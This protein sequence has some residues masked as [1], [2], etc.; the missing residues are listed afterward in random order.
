MSKQTSSI[1]GFLKGHFRDGPFIGLD[2]QTSSSSGTT[3]ED[4]AFFYQP[5][6]TITFSIGTL[7]LGHTAGAESLT[8]ANLHCRENESGTLD[9]TRSETIN[10]ARF[11]LSLGLEPDLRSGVL[12][13]SAIRQAVDVQ[14]AGIDFAFDVDVF[15]RA[16]PVRAV[17]DQLG[18]R[19]R[20][21]AEAR[22]HVRR[23]LLG[24]RAFRDVRIRVRNGSTLDADVFVPFKQG[25]YPVLL[26]LSVYGRAF[27]IG[28]NHTQEDREASDERETTWWEDPKSRE[29]INSYFRYSESA[30]SANASDWVP[31]GYVVVRVDARGIG[32]NSGTL[33]PFSLQEA[34]DFYDAIQWAAEQPWSDGNV[35][36]YGASYNGTIQWNVAALQPPA[37]KAIAP[38][39]PDADG[40]RDLAYPGG[41]FLDKYRRYWYDEIVGPAKNPKVPRVNFVGWLASHPWDDEYYHGQGQGMLSADFSKVHIPVLTSV[42]Q[43]L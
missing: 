33:D 38:L 30:V 10:R 35:G 23:G 37:L 31:R 42:S 25:K 20:G 13:N 17:F 1:Q 26:R 2:Y 7:T 6:E 18:R 41:L 28:S 15:D 36:I 24:I 14:A 21:P 8:L 32:Q 39:A 34:L 16:A 43:T 19:F 22:N 3:D 11:V 9:L 29:K 5:G 27:T 40:Y 12:I 4:G